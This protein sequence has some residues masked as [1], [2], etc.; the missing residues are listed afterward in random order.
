MVWLSHIFTTQ[1][2]CKCKTLTAQCDTVSHDKD[3]SSRSETSDTPYPWTILEWETTAIVAGKSA[4]T[5]VTAENRRSR[6][7]V[8]FDDKELTTSMHSKPVV[9][10]CASCSSSSSD[11]GISTSSAFQASANSQQGQ[12]ALQMAMIIRT[13]C[14]IY[15]VNP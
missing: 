1:L 12:L 13:T 11:E 8:T 7:S 6:S 3:D 9:I 5:T 10:Q 4:F 2:G 15:T 14:T